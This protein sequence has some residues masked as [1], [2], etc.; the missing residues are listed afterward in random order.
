MVSNTV[1]NS[2]I[3][4]IFVIIIIMIVKPNMIY[5]ETRKNLVPIIFIILAVMS[6]YLFALL[7]A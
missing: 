1:K 5:D 4:Y 3:F 7:H 6:Y 2:I